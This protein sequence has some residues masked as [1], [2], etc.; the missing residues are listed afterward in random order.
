MQMQEEPQG[1]S[2]CPD[3]ILC[4]HFPD[5]SFTKELTEYNPKT[6]I[7][8]GPFGSKAC[9]VFCR[10]LS[11]QQWGGGREG[12]EAAMRWKCR[13]WD[14]Q[15]S[16]RAFS[17]GRSPE[18]AQPLQCPRERLWEGFQ[19]SLSTCPAA[20]GEGAKAS[21][22]NSR[23]GISGPLQQSLGPLC[24][25]TK[26]QLL[27]LAFWALHPKGMIVSQEKSAHLSHRA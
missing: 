13:R 1:S 18:E 5:Y 16:L 14:F 25:T 17:P 10:T 12:R 19:P 24:P 4:S 11:Q 23:I 26:Q 15:T 9:R 2:F 20:P 8:C 21:G 6:S 3:L 27:S 7:C 22:S